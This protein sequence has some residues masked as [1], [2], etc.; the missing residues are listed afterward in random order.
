M[1]VADIF[2]SVKKLYKE[3]TNG[4]SA[5]CWTEK[6]KPISSADVIGNAT[7]LLKLKE[8]IESHKRIRFRSTG[9]IN[10][11]YNFVPYKL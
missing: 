11:Y 8:W 3:A 4:D 5:L 9:N 1:N 10:I 2:S 7:C 6:Y